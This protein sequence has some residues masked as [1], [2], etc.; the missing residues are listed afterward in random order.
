MYKKFAKCV[1]KLRNLCMSQ[2][3]FVDINK[4][5]GD[6]AEVTFNSLYLFLGFGNKIEDVII[7]VET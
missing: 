6:N 2:L 5:D 3:P 1:T 7:D 4:G